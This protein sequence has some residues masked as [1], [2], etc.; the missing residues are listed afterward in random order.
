VLEESKR[1]IMVVFS[2]GALHND[3]FSKAKK[4]LWNKGNKNEEKQAAAILCKSMVREAIEG[5]RIIW[6]R[7]CGFSIDFESKEW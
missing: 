4:F 3:V 6:L 7:K 2:L 5:S 1:V